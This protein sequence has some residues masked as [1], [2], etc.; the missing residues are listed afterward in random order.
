M[1][2][3]D[4]KIQA[5]DIN[6]IFA[7]AL[8]QAYASRDSGSTWQNITPLSSLFYDIHFLTSN[9]GWGV[10]AS[11]YFSGS[12]L[13]EKGSHIVLK[14]I[15]GGK[16]WTQLTVSKLQK[17][18]L[19][20]VYFPN[21]QFGLI[22]TDDGHLLRT[23]DGL[24]WATVATPLT[25][26][27]NKMSFSSDRKGWVA[28]RTYD[29]SYED[30]AVEAYQIWENRGRPENQDLDNWLSAERE[31]TRR[32]GLLLSTDGGLKWSAFEPFSGVRQ[33]VSVDDR[34]IFLLGQ[35]ASTSGCF[36]SND[37]GQTWKKISEVAQAISFI[38]DSV[39]WAVGVANSGQLG[40][41]SDGGETWSF[42][43]IRSADGFEANSVVDVHAT[44]RLNVWA[45]GGSYGGPIIFRS[46]DGGVMWETA[47]FLSN[48]V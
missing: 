41:T 16:T 45:I 13:L 46:R 3:Y 2:A 1:E 9:L 25:G 39:G 28:V 40:R 15:D 6:H 22:G 12:A 14:T 37:G 18:S 4:Y 38:S 26:I 20:A 43:G 11:E 8:G 27:V 17:W 44:D 32:G 7:M 34:T 35:S 23:T 24:S 42:S 47:K 21:E 29:P 30:V 48:N 19:S 31:L 33:V 5:V 10:L 36:R